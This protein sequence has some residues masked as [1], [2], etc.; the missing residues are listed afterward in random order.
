MRV[1]YKLSMYCIVLSLHYDA[2][3][4]GLISACDCPLNSLH[5][6][7]ATPIR[8]T[9][10]NVMLSTGMVQLCPTVALSPPPAV[11]NST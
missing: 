2:V 3:F 6:L 5:C 8:L 1:L 7:L 9:A 4:I 10:R 11:N